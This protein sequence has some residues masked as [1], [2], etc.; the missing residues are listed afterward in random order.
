MTGSNN[1]PLEK[2]LAKSRRNGRELSL[3]Q[4]LRDTED[5]ALRIFR[6]DGRW[7]Q[8][9]CRFFK[10]NDAESQER[11][12]LNLRVAALFHDIG[13]ANEDFHCA[14]TE[15]GFFEQ[16]LRHEHLSALLLCFPEVRQWLARNNQLDA[17]VITAAVL[18][19]HLKAAESGEENKARGWKWC[20]PRGQRNFVRLYMQHAEVDATLERI[21]A[22][23]GLEGKPELKFST[24]SPAESW[25]QMAWLNGTTS[26]RN[27]ARSIRRDKQRLALLLAVK[28]GVI[29][30][31]SA[32][33]GLFRENLSLEE[34]I[35]NVVHDK[36]ISAD[37]VADKI[38]NPRAEQISKKHGMPFSL[39]PFQEKAA[40]Q[41]SRAL[42]LAACAAG[43]TI[44]AWKWAEAQAREHK[45]GRV[46]FLYPTR[47]TATEG[48]R[49]YVGWAPEAE[50]A[51]VAGDAKFMLEDVA[52]NPSD[53]TA[54]KNFDNLCED[55]DRLYALG[56]WSRRY[57]SATVDQFLGFMEHSYSSL[58]LL[59]ALTDSAVIIDEVH[60]FDQRMFDCLI[61][62][63]KN[64]EMPVLCMT[65]TLP[66]NR[67]R[68]LQDVGL[69]LYQA[70]EDASLHKI[71]SHPRYRLEPVANSDAALEQ[72]VAAYRNG[73]RVLWVVNRVAECQRIAALLEATLD[74]D[75]LTYH[76][77]FRLQDRKDVHAATV[78]AFQQTDKPVIAVTTQVCEMSLDL[79]ADVLISEVAPIPSLVQRFGRANR[80]LDG[81]PPDFRARLLTYKP[82]KVLPYD[83]KELEAATTFLA[84]FGTGDV[85]QRQLAEALERH[86]KGEPLSEGNSRFL[87]SGYFAVRGEF[88]DIDE[89]AL[90]CVL[91]TDLDEV[92]TLVKARKPYDGFIVNVPKSHVLKSED[93]ERP[94]WLPKYLHLANGDLYSRKR[95][96]LT[97]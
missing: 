45:I 74:V 40:E 55:Q 93:V 97:E 62:Y 5:A 51:Y 11:F 76:S 81:K 78:K 91:T 21:A 38:L 19:H 82:E 50:A 18:S 30:A 15:K 96:F 24:W 61:G 46:I 68:Q 69:K 23:A 6:L 73:S 57:F 25:V 52:R 79:D 22:I 63:L 48:F 94:A 60:S 41:G 47:G 35:E 88:R 32:A 58:C 33:S 71:E 89:F 54:G 44:A 10:L 64:F 53:A 9:W 20:Q 80:H 84:E 49:D 12:L 66:P 95:G 42:L 90:P 4:H 34:W 59:P 65:A 67:I 56:L 72:V 85:S 83:A 37:E 31:D 75:V 28:A 70:S 86:A 92:K 16:T 17:D 7:G 2:L 43:K 77:R 27:L 14:V 87:E 36:A 39:H 8:N 13:K 1:Q 29:V 3:E 26:A